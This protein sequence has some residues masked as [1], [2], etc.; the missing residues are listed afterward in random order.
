M[1]FIKS[2][3]QYIIYNPHIIL[4]VIAIIVIFFHALYYHLVYARQKV[5][6]KR[7]GLIYNKIIN[8]CI[9]FLG[10]FF[11]VFQSKYFTYNPVN[12]ILSFGLIIPFLAIIIISRRTLGLH[13]SPEVEIHSEHKYINKGIYKYIDHP[14]Y[15]SE[16]LAATG[17]CLL[18]NH[19]L[20]YLG[21][22]I[23]ISGNIYRIFIETKLLK[24]TFPEYT[25]LFKKVIGWI[26]FL[27]NKN[28]PV[29]KH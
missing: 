4:L 19:P 16:I 17:G 9:Y 8:A 7:R 2:L 18:I 24:E 1:D 29:I 3:F 11:I 21:L 13:Y 10:I 27:K 23:F 12:E 28:L 6:I 22:F 25:T 5:I 26:Y 15:Y 20:Y 14:V